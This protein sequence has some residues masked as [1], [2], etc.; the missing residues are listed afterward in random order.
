M[1]SAADQ[2]YESILI[3]G[4][5]SYNDISNQMIKLYWIAIM[6]FTNKISCLEYSFTNK[7]R[8][9]LDEL[10]EIL[11]ETAKSINQGGGGGEGAG[12]GGHLHQ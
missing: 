12:A 1:N 6:R 9:K 8:I 5:I 2:H 7:I 10:D 4:A 3:T 11:E